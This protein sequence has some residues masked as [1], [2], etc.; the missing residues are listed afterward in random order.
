M[1]NAEDEGDVG[2]SERLCRAK[3]N[4]LPTNYHEHPVVKRN[5]NE[6]A[7]PVAL[8]MAAVP[9]SLTDS[10]GIWLVHLLSRQRHPCAASGNASCVNAAVGGGGHTE[11]F[12]CLWSGADSLVSFFP[13][14]G[15]MERHFCRTPTQSALNLLEHA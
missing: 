8:Y 14:R 3:T 4:V 6:D 12:V 5:P 7:F 10:V 9:Y 11:S 15:T 2:L 13:P 1:F